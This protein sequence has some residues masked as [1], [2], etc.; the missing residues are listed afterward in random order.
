MILFIAFCFIATLV[1]AY[2]IWKYEDEH[3][4]NDK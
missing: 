3:R 1:M 4:S 2:N